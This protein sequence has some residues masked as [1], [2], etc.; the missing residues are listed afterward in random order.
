MAGGTEPLPLSDSDFNSDMEYENEQKTD[1]NNKI[2]KE[3]VLEI[4]MHKKYARKRQ[5]K[6][7]TE[8]SSSR[9]S[10]TKEIESVNKIV[11]GKKKKKNK[12][13]SDK[14]TI[15]ENFRKQSKDPR[16]ESGSESNTEEDRAMYT[17]RSQP[18]FFVYIKYV[19]DNG[20]QEA[21]PLSYLEAS[22]R[23]TKA[24]VNFKYIAKHANSWKVTFDT[25]ALANEATKN[26]V[27]TNMGIIP[28][29]P[30]FKLLRKGVIK[31]VPTNVTDKE[32]T[33]A[34]KEDNK[35]IVINKIFRLKR[36]EQ[37]TGKW[38]N[39][40]SVCIEFK[41][42]NLPQDIK[43]WRAKVPV[44]IYIPQVRCFRCGRIGHISKGCE[45]QQRCLICSEAYQ[46][47]K[48]KD[49]R[50]TKEKKCINC[51]GD[52]ST[53]DRICPKFQVSAEINKTMALDNISFIEARKTV[54]A[55]TIPTSGIQRNLIKDTK[56]FPILRRTSDITNTVI[57][58]PISN[59][60]TRTGSSSQKKVS[61]SPSTLEEKIDKISCQNFDHLVGIHAIYSRSGSFN[62][63]NY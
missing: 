7:I 12:M 10:E 33:D 43:I 37:S 29:I 32:L 14:D 17:E 20:N 56:N 2:S 24:K 31:R 44:S 62:A 48:D 39:S 23:I 63:K 13:E 57:S 41:G 11:K 54:L 6:E 27:L 40:Q 36:K 19:K 34:L 4:I 51:S 58:R 25:S 18:P 8:E 28:Y 9:L 38:I 35:G 21:R 16:I 47:E 26:E 3:E 61:I 30:R 50:C 49:K 46:I 42:Q 52:H 53:L 60:P 1:I 59:W 55:R 22:R 45:A 15:K 5:R